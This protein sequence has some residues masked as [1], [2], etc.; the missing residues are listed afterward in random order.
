MK[1]TLRF[2][3]QVACLHAVPLNLLRS[4]IRA[5]YCHPFT[6]TSRGW[7]ILGLLTLTGISA[8]LGVSDV[9][10]GN[11][12]HIN[13]ND[14]GECVSLNDPQ[15][16]YIAGAA[17]DRA[18]L[19]ES[20]N[21]KDSQSARCDSSV[22]RGQTDSVMFF[23]P[24]E[25]PG[26][27]ATSL[28]LGGELYINSG[29]LMLGGANG[30]ITIG[31]TGDRVGSALATDGGFA[32]GR[33]AEST[34]PWTMAF[35]LL[36][37]A[38]NPYALSFGN[39]ATASNTFSTAFGSASTASGTY[40]TTL[41]ASA[42][43]G[44]AGAFAGGRFAVSRGDNAVAIGRNASAS[45]LESL[46]L[47]YS[48]QAP[49]NAGVALGGFSA[50]DDLRE[51][52]S[53]SLNGHA[54]SFDRSSAVAT[55]SGGSAAR[56]RQW[57]FVAPGAVTATSTDAINGAQLFSGYEAVRR[58]GARET[59]AGESVAQ[60]LGTGPLAQ[61]NRVVPAPLGLTSLAPGTPSPTTLLGAL[62][63]LDKAHKVSDARM[64]EVFDTALD[65]SE[66]AQQLRATR[67]FYWN[68][69]S[70]VYDADRDAGVPTSIINMAA[71]VVA[72][73]AVNK[74]QLADVESSALRAQQAADTANV[75]V[76]K[77]RQE[78]LAARE[79]A[80][81]SLVRA[82]SASQDAASALEA[83][84]F[85]QNSADAA[86][87]AASKA[88]ASATNA[89]AVAARAD[90]AAASAQRSAQIAQEVATGAQSSANTAQ[91]L[92]AGAQTRVKEAENTV[93]HATAVAN[94]ALG[95][96]DAA[97]D[98]VTSAQAAAAAAQDRT[99]QA[100]TAASSAQEAADG[101]QR[102]ADAAVT[103]GKGAEMAADTAQA[104][105]GQALSVAGAVQDAAAAAQ[106][107]AD[108]AAGAA[109]SAQGAGE[110][111]R[112][113][114]DRAQDTAADALNATGSA[115]VSANVALGAATAAETTAATAWQTADSAGAA[116]A[117]AQTNAQN[118]LGSAK[119]AHDT[120]AS[121]QDLANVARRSADSALGVL[122]S[123]QAST[124]GAQGTADVALS[125]AVQ[126]QRSADAAQDTAGAAQ[127]FAGNASNTAMAARNRADTALGAASIA[128]EAANAADTTASRA[129]SLATGA[130]TSAQAAHGT[131]D[132]ASA[133]ASGAQQAAQ[134]T[135]VKANVVLA[136]ASTAQTAAQTAQGAADH[137]LL[138]ASK[139]DEK[140]RTVQGSANAAVDAANTAQRTA[141]TAHTT[142]QQA[143]RTSIDAMNAAV[144]AQSDADQTQGVAT[145]ANHRAFAA[146]ARASSALSASADA[147]RAADNAQG[148]AN[149]A[150]STADVVTVQL[151]GLDTEQTVVQYLDAAVTAAAGLGREAV[152]RLLGGGSTLD[153][154]G[155]PTA[156]AYGIS[157]T[158]AD[159]SVQPA[160]GHDNAGDALNAVA[161]NLSTLN[162]AVLT[163][164]TALEALG[165]DIQGLR[166]D[167]L[168]WVG[169]DAAYT[170]GR[171]HSSSEPVRIAQL[172]PGRAQADAV[173][174]DQLDQ[175]DRAALSAH[176]IAQ[177]GHAVADRA[178]SAAVGATDAAVIAHTRAD[179]AKESATAVQTVVA[180]ARGDADAAHT[181]A[182]IAGHVADQSATRLQ[183]I[184][185]G[186][187]VL[188]HIQ[189]AA[190]AHDQAFAT[191]VGG[192][193]SVNADGSTGAPTYTVTQPGQKGAGA[194]SINA[195]TIGQA[196]DL[197]NERVVVADDQS[198][199]V[200]AQTDSLRKQMDGGEVGLARQDPVS[201][202]I[203]LAG[204]TDGARFDIGGSQGLRT[205][206]GV[207]DG[208][209]SSTSGDAVNGRQLEA[210]NQQVKQLDRQS[211][212]V[213]VDVTEIGESASTRSGSHSV[214]IGAQAQAEGERSVATGGGATARADQSTALG[215]QANADAANSVALGA[216]SHVTRADSVAVGAYGAE[217]QI[218]H[219][220]EATR[221]TDAVN[222]RQSTRLS[223]Q[224]AN[225]SL[226]DANAYTD[227]RLGSLR[228]DVYA[229]VATV[230][231]TA[232]LP[233]ASS[234]GKSMVAMATAV[235]EGQ[236][237]LAVGLTARS[238]GGRWTYRATGAG[239]AQGDFGL[240]VGL[241]YHW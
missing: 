77:A 177:T 235:Y 49:Q 134:D 193:A 223:N 65:T 211:S 23:R 114:A 15:S 11:G 236:P 167:T 101:A 1:V 178:Q 51:V 123:A 163:Q 239:T 115:Q 224:A 6:V 188:E 29:R 138:I 220:A 153:A 89:Q 31:Q 12:V 66:K 107:I 156:P 105:A 10:A 55:V 205:L 187:T 24:S 28:S 169:V 86:A 147:Q 140:A 75:A 179:A 172:A 76:D 80:D 37:K 182:S 237:A 161:S 103:A 137:A 228:Q 234:P 57:I 22:K 62:A 207:E 227:R 181:R 113:M 121:A 157:V 229:G 194:E 214:A 94:T 145:E 2:D 183:G 200:S 16:S 117:T 118:A 221:G 231:A 88:G 93:D 184:A 104:A 204:A 171:G 84:N 73:D 151:A 54:Y 185:P 126:A 196:F 36:A 238:R 119:T 165:G 52:A 95:S 136:A 164:S 82:N 122:E 120:A 162:D 199:A 173:N 176:S 42:Q 108:Q 110:L 91:A 180:I 46:A 139:V 154:Q 7:P 186:E 232:G 213:A 67:K 175:A 38:Q 201:R 74:G 215:P 144:A 219:V 41:G 197:L 240:T 50:T 43:A 198:N 189:S 14:S 8:L 109:S 141:D 26:V 3:S 61:G 131:A 149:A 125:S 230:M 124:D 81:S 222:F 195:D 78:S 116:A 70:G 208:E 206:G 216:G 68:P 203:Q 166:D 159:G 35:G 79:A 150:H 160:V 18:Y 170:A 97:S 174:K 212:G 21:F 111:A 34:A 90:I 128:Q 27:G 155:Q 146:Q 98:A 53:V 218:I 99:D 129:L 133:A 30:S 64:G 226:S 39:T 19:S 148:T 127:G 72:T 217:R 112:N 59:T 130:Q 20:L 25:T 17:A 168:Q 83:A 209:V 71:G 63:A 92:A 4:L 132:T 210:V 202:D 143:A 142:A 106:D 58:L 48:A 47:G 56:L 102:A 69:Q 33:G 13:G 100:A 87:S 233:V 225:R 32:F 192:G 85:A 152:T 241:G 9:R 135:Q 40:A 190:R 44:G 191:A 96:A 45:N 60:A 158:A 5:F